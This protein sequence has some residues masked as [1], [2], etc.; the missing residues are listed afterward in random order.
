MGASYLAV[1]DFGGQ[2]AHLIARRVREL[3]YR[4]RVF[5]P[6][7]RLETLTEAKGVILSGGPRSVFA[8]DAVPFNEELLTPESATSGPVL[9]ASAAG[10]PSGGDG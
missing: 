8:A 4:S 9:W 2:Y 7:V 6:Q 3:G 10:A 1:V 5:S